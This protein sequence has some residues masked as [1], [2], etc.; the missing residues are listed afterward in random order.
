MDAKKALQDL[1]DVKKV[2]DKYQ[3]KF[4]LIYGTALGAYR[5]GKFLKGDYDIDLGSFG[6]EHKDKIREDLEKLGFEIGVLFDATTQEI[7][8][9]DMVLSERNVRVD[10]FFFKED[11][12]E[13]VAWKHPFSFHPFMAMPLK[14]KKTEKVTLYGHEFEMLTPAKEYLDYLYGED[15]GI[16]KQGRLYAD[17]HNIKEEKYI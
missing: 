2:F 1:L 9:T 13:Y 12:G 4:F 11:K 14:F 16:K 7:I 10:T 5:D 15:W 17:V 6:T 8:P 3:V